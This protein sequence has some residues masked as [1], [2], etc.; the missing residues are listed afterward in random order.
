M[1]TFFMGENVSRELLDLDN[2]IKELKTKL[3]SDPDPFLVDVLTRLT[4]IKE[5]QQKN[6][7]Y[8]AIKKERL[9]PEGGF[10][11]HGIS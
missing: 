10:R 6:L 5:N 9:S 7:I 11:G 2:T 8:K 3:S 1:N 4:V